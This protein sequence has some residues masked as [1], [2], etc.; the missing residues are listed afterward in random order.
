MIV[1]LYRFLFT[2]LLF[3]L[4]L[5]SLCRL[6]FYLFYS[7][8]FESCT[9]SQI[10]YAFLLGLRFDL[11][12]LLGANVVFFLP[13]AIGR[14]FAIPKWV[15]TIN[16]LLFVLVNSIL[17]SLNLLDLEYFAF[18]G[19]R[20]GI[21]ILGIKDDI[22]NQANQLFLHYWHIA[23]LGFVLFLWILLRTLR[24]TYKP[25]V[26]K[27]PVLYFAIGYALFIGLAV[28]GI[29]S[30][31]QLKPLRPN[32]AFSIQPS[33]L[34]NVVLNTP[35]NIFMTIGIEPIEPVHYF[36]NESEVSDILSEW[37]RQGKSTFPTHTTK[38]NVVIIILESFASEYTGIANAGKGYTPF[39]DSLASTNL[40]FQNHF[41]NGRV[42]M[43]AVPSILASIPG[44]MREPYITSLYQT[45][46]LQ[47][48]G[49]QLLKSGYHTSFFH[50]AKNGSM[51]FDAFTKNADFTHYYG[52]NEYKG[53]QED[54][55]GNW[56]IYDEPYLQYFK[57]HLN[58]F[59]Q[60]F[61]SCVFTISSHQPY[62]LPEK[63]AGKFPEGDLDI[64]KTIGYVDYSLRKFFEA[65][66]KET[67][68]TNTLFVITA[69]HTQMHSNP[70]YKNIRG[71]YN[72]PLIFFH[73]SEKLTADTSLVASQIDIMPSILDYL[74]IINPEPAL[75]GQS[76]FGKQPSHD[77]AV[78][79]SDNNYRVFLK[80]YYIEGTLETEFLIKKYT[81]EIIRPANEKERKLIQA[82]IQ[83]YN[84]G[85]IENTYYTWG[86]TK[87]S[88]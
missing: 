70:K 27:R 15:F 45:N 32:I 13:L 43:E 39:L 63:Y 30:G 62:S 4:F 58:T 14:F 76:V 59:P 31:F 6:L 53:S 61:A 65:A 24:L 60:P 36:K 71:D 67:W 64:H 23:L 47:G 12:I 50:A 80:D 44:L 21:E 40:Y 74:Q 10:A 69:D 75:I 38:Q 3:L 84:N 37:N 9:T 1:A 5:F 87:G 28:L 16:K 7:P 57:E 49:T 66:K 35:F 56:G 2:R 82:I 55:D 26:S 33:K 86:K 8:E 22:G 81:H 17:V 52:L 85:M 11:S 25:V 77:Y 46:A 48:L 42:S 51:G 29:R 72:V 68:Y 34:G 41:A 83:Y 79:F 18:T 20:T 88:I 54:F 73:P 19:K 78:N